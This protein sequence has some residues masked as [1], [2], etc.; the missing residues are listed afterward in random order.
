MSRLGQ[1]AYCAAPLECTYSL[2]LLFLLDG[3]NDY[4]GVSKLLSQEG[5]KRSYTE[6]IRRRRFD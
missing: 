4:A 6:Q 1:S 5:K 2:S 3:R